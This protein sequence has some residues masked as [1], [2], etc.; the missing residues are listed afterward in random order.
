MWYKVSSEHSSAPGKR[1]TDSRLS[2]G[3]RP[4]DSSP[5]ATENRDTYH[6]GSHPASKPREERPL[7]AIVL[8]AGQGRRLLPLT[9]DTP[10]CA[11]PVHG[12]SL[13]EW[14]ID[15]LRRA[16][17]NHVRVV[18]GFGADKVERLLARRFRA[19]QV[20]TLYNPFFTMTDNLVSCW[21]ARVEMNED[22][23]LLNGDTLFEPGVLQRLLSAPHH[24]VTLVSDQKTSY[25]ADDMKITLDGNRLVNIG[26]AL[27]AEQTDGESIGMLLFRGEGPALFSAALEQAIRR[28]EALKQWYLSVIHEMA[29]SGLVDTVSING[30]QWT[31][32]D[33]PADLDQAGELVAGWTA[34]QKLAVGAGPVLESE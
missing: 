16:G 32:V 17:V 19:P 28:P 26:K 25:D 22:F 7:K 9:T 13:I 6:G 8:S 2:L 29:Q 12:Q 21:V 15:A 20:R 30:L 23:L 14:Q 18:L 4:S 11:L 10:K 34:A 27:P 31:E 3:D 24:P 5:W 1:L 33:S